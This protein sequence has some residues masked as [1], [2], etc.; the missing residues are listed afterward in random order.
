MYIL[1]GPHDWL[2]TS[3]LPLRCITPK[4]QHMSSHLFIQPQV[5]MSNTKKEKKKVKVK[6]EKSR[7]RSCWWSEA[8]NTLLIKTMTMQK[9]A[10]S[11]GDNNPKPTVWVACKKVL[12]SSEKESGGAP[13]T[14]GVLK[15]QWKKVLYINITSMHVHI[16]QSTAQKRIW[17]CQGAP[18]SI[19][20]WLGQCNEACASSYMGWVPQGMPDPYI[21]RP[22]LSFSLSPPLSPFQ[23]HNKVKLF[24][25]KG[26]PLF[27][28][29]GNLIDSTCATGEFM[30]WAGQNSGPSNTWHS[31]PATPSEDNIES[32]IN[33]ILLDISKDTTLTHR[34]HT[35]YHWEDD[36]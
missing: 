32:Q 2:Q 26:F 23:S 19:G 8:N 27:N 1:C 15:S 3:G 4:A 17:Y 5:A 31:S 22:D 12:A 28:K 30:F 34:P 14:I 25:R 33:P 6:E 10:G 11:W 20:I 7:G 21:C 9:V 36:K 35:P 16:W 13:K 24:H 18:E 29:I